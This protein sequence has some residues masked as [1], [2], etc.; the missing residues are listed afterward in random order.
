ILRRTEASN[1]VVYTVGL[2]DELER[3]ANPKALKHLAGAS[4]GEAFEPHHVRDVTEVLRHIARDIR[5]SYTI[6][7]VPTNPDH[8]GT[9]RAIRVIVRPPAGRQVV[10]RTRAGY[11]AGRASEERRP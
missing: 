9:F 4:G 2:L 1:V 10:V 8:D 11:L 6:G 7:Y 5:H 3:E